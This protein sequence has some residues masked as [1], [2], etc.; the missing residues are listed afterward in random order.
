MDRRGT[1]RQSV[2]S[3]FETP[4]DASLVDRV[5]DAHRP[6]LRGVGHVGAAVGLAV[7]VHDFDDA[8]LA[9]VL[10]DEVHVGADQVRQL[11]G[12]CPGQGV[13][14]DLA[15]GGERLVELVLDLL[16]DL[17]DAHAFQGEIHART[18]AVV[19]DVAAGHVGVPAAPHDARERVQRRVQPHEPEAPL[20]VQ[21]AAD[22]GAGRGRIAFDRVRDLAGASLHA[23]H[24]PHLVTGP[25]LAGVAR[26]A[27]RPADRR[28]CGQAPRRPGRPAGLR[29]RTSRR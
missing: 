25:Q 17:V 10:G 23:G 5:D 4:V 18:V 8:D 28:R 13:D 1:C 6:D 29:P 27:R 24:R 21:A 26:V 16:L 20:P 19:G 7:E 14:L 22:L 2:E 15:P 9:D 12:F 11:E 3:D